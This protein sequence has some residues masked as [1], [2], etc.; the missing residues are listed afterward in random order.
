MSALSPPLAPDLFEFDEDVVWAMH[1][2]EGPV[3]TAASDEV[4]AF[5]ER[6]RKPWRLRFREDFVDLPAATRREAARLIGGDASDVTLT[7]TTST[8]LIAIAQGLAWNDGDEIV[9]PLGEFPSNAWPWRALEERGVVVREV[10]LW[11]GHRAGGDALAS[12][13][14]FA[15]ADPEWRLAEALG[16]RTRLVAA[17]WVR[18]QDGLRLDLARLGAACRSR[19]VPLIVD[20]IQGAGTLPSP[21]AD[22]VVAF[23]TGGHKGVLAPQ[24]L[25]FLWTDATFRASMMPTGS[26]LSVEDACDFSRPSTD[27][28]RAWLPNGERLEAGVPNLVGCAALRRSLAL[29]NEAGVERIAAHVAALERKFLDALARTDGWADEATRLRALLDA[30]R[31]GAIVALHHGGRGDDALQARLRDGFGRGVYASVREGYLRVALHGWHREGDVARIAAWL[32][33]GL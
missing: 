26:W 17:S 28:D 31:L 24:G 6:E 23:A 15:D 7:A 4:V 3:P 22:G 29:I 11:D 20:G 32:G 14:P 16:P 30:G 21:L 33:D 1:C 13:P 25:G 19:G 8:G 10:P 2:A 5:L 12:A 9:V 27:F 18:F